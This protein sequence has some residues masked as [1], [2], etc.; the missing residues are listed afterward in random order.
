[1]GVDRARGRVLL[2]A[3][4][5]RELVWWHPDTRAEEPGPQPAFPGVETTRKVT[6]SPNGAWL[7]Y[8]VGPD[9]GE[10]WRAS[11]TDGGFRRVHRTPSGA[12]AGL[13]AITDDGHALVVETSR[14]GE[15][16]RLDAGADPW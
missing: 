10:L 15:L 13:S 7:L 6:L 8:Q 14:Q 3:P 9:G 2:A 4:T 5:P 12:S 16:W 11:T 1:L